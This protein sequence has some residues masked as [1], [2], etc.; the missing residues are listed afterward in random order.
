MKL[1]FCALIRKKLCPKYLHRYERRG[2]TGR[3]FRVI[4]EEL[5]QLFYE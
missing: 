3:R 2:I 1:K 4:F 5:N